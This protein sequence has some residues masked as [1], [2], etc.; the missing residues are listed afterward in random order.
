MTDIDL[1]W[2]ASAEDEGRT[3]KPSEFKIKKARE[4]GRVAKSQEVTGALVMLLPIL[5]IL[6]LAP[7]FYKN[8][9]QIL[10]TNIMQKLVIASL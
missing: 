5:V 4:E 1:Q 9:V 6:A 8:C 2:F 7:W 3:E 10:K